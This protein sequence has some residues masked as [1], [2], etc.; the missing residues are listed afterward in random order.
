MRHDLL[1]GPRAPQLP[2][3]ITAVV[4]NSWPA[5][6][7][8]DGA[9][10]TAFAPLSTGTSLRL[11]TRTQGWRL[12]VDLNLPQPQTRGGDHVLT[13]AVEDTH[14]MPHHTRVAQLWLVQGDAEWF[15]HASR[16]VKVNLMS[17]LYR[18]CSEVQLT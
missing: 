2:G 5:S 8:Q 15:L 12:V 14:G 4:R 17:S 16:I 7:A 3:V 18:L 10:H 6:A 1:T 11:R 13:P 9:G